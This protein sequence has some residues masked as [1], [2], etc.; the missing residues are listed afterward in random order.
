MLQKNSDI[1]SK[2]V[3]P[4]LQITSPPVDVDPEEPGSLE[5]EADGSN[6]VDSLTNFVHKF[7]G[8]IV[9]C[10]ALKMYQLL[11]HSSVDQFM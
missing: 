9:V 6:L 3:D 1:P 11:H 4:S 5:P 10:V 7:R 8:V 2:V